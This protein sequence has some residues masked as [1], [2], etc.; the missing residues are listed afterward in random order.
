MAKRRPVRPSNASE[1][2]EEEV[3]ETPE[4]RRVRRQRERRAREK[5]G[6]KSVGMFSAWPRWKT[7][8]VLGG[9][10]V[11]VAAAIGVVLLL[12]SPPCLAIS[13]PP[14][15]SGV[16][17]ESAPSWCVNSTVSMD[18]RLAVSLTITV[19]GAGVAIPGGIGEIN[20]HK[21]GWTCNMP[22]FTDNATG[23]GG[24]GSGGVIQIVSPWDFTYTLGDF[25]N[26]WKESY[27]TV[28][29][30]G[31][32]EPV[33]YTGTQLFNY[34]STSNQVVRLWVDGQQSN[35]GPGLVLNYLSSNYA[36]STTVPQCFLQKYGSGHSI[37][38]TW[39]WKGAGLV[40]GG[41]TLFVAP[42]STTALFPTP[43]GALSGPVHGST[44][45]G[46]LALTSGGAALLAIAALPPSGSGGPPDQGPGR[47]PGANLR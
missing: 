13:A 1:V 28:S 34:S 10:A 7:A 14:A 12:V 47:G 21:W 42:E 31:V 41:P 29:I 9:S 44:L 27:S 35:A 32:A 40:I 37:T 4:E 36:T 6:P 15:S 38:L 18:Q 24:S 33:S 5:R 30:N 45:T 3:Q 46:V 20:Q 22:V 17:D 25:F 8:A 26:M 11:A 2:E 43:V 23:P 19:G 16:P 39:G